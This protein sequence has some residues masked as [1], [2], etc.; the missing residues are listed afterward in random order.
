VSDPDWFLNRYVCPFRDELVIML[1]NVMLYVR[2][3]LFTMD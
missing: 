3:Y 2:L 1:Y